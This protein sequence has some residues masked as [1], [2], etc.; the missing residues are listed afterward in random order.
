MSGK[1]ALANTDHMHNWFCLCEHDLLST[2][3]GQ[4]PEEALYMQYFDAYMSVRLVLL[5]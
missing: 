1:N 3:K 5:F 2:L 4:K